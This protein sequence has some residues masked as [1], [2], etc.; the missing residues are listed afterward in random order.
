MNYSLALKLKEAGFGQE[1]RLG[2]GNGDM[3]LE[4]KKGLVYVP[5][6]SELI[7]AIGDRFR[8]IELRQEDIEGG[9]WVAYSRENDDINCEVSIFKNGQTPEEAVA[10]LWLEIN[11]K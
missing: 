9:R 7:E 1:E 8:N 6:L 5:T 10:N 2:I 3:F 4:G 11:K